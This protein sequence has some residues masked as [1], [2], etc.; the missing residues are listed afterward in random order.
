MI[1]RQYPLVWICICYMIGILLAEKGFLINLWTA[2]GIFIVIFLMCLICLWIDFEHLTIWGVFLVL[3]GLGYISH[4]I[5]LERKE[6]ITALKGTYRFYGRILKPVKQK[7]QHELVEIEMKELGGISISGR[8]KAAYKGKMKEEIVEGLYVTGVIKYTG[9]EKVSDLKF[10]SYLRNGN[11][12]GWGWIDS[13]EVIQDGWYGELNKVYQKLSNHIRSHYAGFTQHLAL[14]LI[15]GNKHSFLKEERN[16]FY[17]SGTAHLL[18]VSGMHVGILFSFLSLII[19]IMNFLRIRPFWLHLCFIPLL[20]FYAFLTGESISAFRSI[21]M[22]SMFLFQGLL[23]RPMNRIQI[24]AFSA[25]LQLLYSPSFLFHPSFQFSYGAMSGIFL[26][27]PLLRATYKKIRGGMRWCMDSINISISAQWGVFPFLLLYWKKF[28]VYFLFA[29]LFI[30]PL[31]VLFC[32]IL[33]IE[34]FLFLLSMDQYLLSF[35]HPIVNILGKSIEWGLSR[36]INLPGKEISFSTKEMIG[37]G[38]IIWLILFFFL[39]FWEKK[40]RRKN[41]IDMLVQEENLLFYRFAL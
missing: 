21:L 6:K 2:L 28:P 35:L 1:L 10:Q 18:A 17:L 29:N 39:V 7:E 30:G 32:Y 24:L 33:F 20:I 14:A 12:L 19:H 13:I 11:Y 37:F 31:V 22:T 4:T 23:P 41:L 8:L 5:R 16:W 3:I 38:I 40:L 36:F 9:T 27:S 34:A 26:L 15:L 25:F